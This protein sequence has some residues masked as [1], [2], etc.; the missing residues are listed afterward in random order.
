MNGM[1]LRGIVLCVMAVLLW[2]FSLPYIA[3]TELVLEGTPERKVIENPALPIRADSVPESVRFSVT[4]IVRHLP[5]HRDTIEL[6]F[7]DC[8]ES[9][10]INGKAVDLKPLVEKLTKKIQEKDRHRLCFYARIDASD[11]LNFGDNTVQMTVSDD[12]GIIYTAN[13]MMPALWIVNVLIVLLGVSGA[14]LVM[15]AVRPFSPEAQHDAAQVAGRPLPAAFTR[16]LEAP[17][18]RWRA[19]LARSVRWAEPDLR[20]IYAYFSS[21]PMLRAYHYLA[22]ATLVLSGIVMLWVS[23]WV[24]RG[25]Y[26][27]DLPFRFLPIPLVF[28][29]W[30]WVTEKHGAAPIPRRF[31]LFYA[32]LAC[33]AFAFAPAFNDYERPA[34]SLPLIAATV[35]ALLVLMPPA[36]VVERARMFPRMTGAACFAAAAALIYAL[37]QELLW[38]Q[39]VYLSS[40][41]IAGIGH[42]LDLDMV[43]RQWIDPDEKRVV[44]SLLSSHFGVHLYPFC[45]GIE[46]MVLFSALLSAVILYDWKLFERQRLWPLYAIGIVYMFFVNVLRITALFLL[47]NWA[48]A[49][50][51]SEFAQSFRGDMVEMFHSQIGW[52]LYAMAF[53]IF[54]HFLYPRLMRKQK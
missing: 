16:W 3:A 51:A 25:A 31:S 30:L 4:A 17:N 24:P 29:F 40:I 22:P 45:S 19:P 8:L 44:I 41:A 34:M 10:S 27:A 18:P 21:A 5:W 32:C 53:G 26:L 54:M 2:N 35:S 7:D 20:R 12:G 33:A 14:A 1:L 15:A 6:T 42:A 50:D 49:P 13:I 28:S 48:H 11:Y 46:G 9:L 36:A 47:G 39:M 52:I 37:A 43:T 23:Q 38:D